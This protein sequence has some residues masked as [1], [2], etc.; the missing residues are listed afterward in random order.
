MSRVYLDNNATTPPLPEVIE[1]VAG[2]MRSAWGNPS[3]ESSSGEQ[4]REEVERARESVAALIGCDPRSVVFTSGGT[5]ANNLAIMAGLDVR[6]TGRSR[7][8][9]SGIEHA[10]VLSM[11]PKLERSGIEIVTV[12]SDSS[13]RV[14]LDEFLAAIDERTAAVSLQW[15]NNETGVVQPV[16]EVAARCREMGVFFHTDGCQ[17]VGKLAE[18]FSDIDFDA[19]TLTAHKFHGPK[20]VGAVALRK[21]PN[22]SPILSGGDQE[23]GVRPGTENVAGIVGL[24]EAAR[25]R[26]QRLNRVLPQM[27][28]LRDRFECAIT[29]ELPEIRVNGGDSDRVGN[30]TNLLFPGVHGAAM[31]NNLDL[32]GIEC[33]Q[34]S[35]CTRARPEPSH[36]LTAM[37][38]SEEE[39]YSSV[40]FSFSELNT[41]EET[42]T[43]I[44]TIIEVYRTLRART[45]ALVG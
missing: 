21:P 4:A 41:E 3:N 1:A 14:R 37:G 32:H 44:A 12:G 9:T 5:E 39:A 45:M 24:G 18:T 13:G 19:F 30:A 42:D 38:L 11:L 6:A 22:S 15:A 26:L 10:S 29:R 28:G 27:A 25:L 17:A 20:G 33:S 34:S 31:V 7:F 43:A 40:R 36:V 2:A 35:A 23:F 16:A 8:V